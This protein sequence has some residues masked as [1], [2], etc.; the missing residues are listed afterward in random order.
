HDSPGHDHDDHHQIMDEEHI[1][2]R[3]VQKMAK[4]LID[5]KRNEYALLI[6]RHILHEDDELFVIRNL[7]AN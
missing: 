6:P 4:D 1:K 7:Q 3:R 2:A 5:I